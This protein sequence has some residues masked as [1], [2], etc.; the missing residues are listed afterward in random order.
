MDKH[1]IDR[2]KRQVNIV[3][4][5]DSYVRLKKN[6]KN[7]SACCPFH[8][9]KTPSFT[10]SEDKQF[11]YCFGCGAKGD[12]IDWLTE[13]AQMDFV[14]AIKS[15][16]GEIEMTDPAKIA[17]N[18]KRAPSIRKLKDHCEEPE[19][20]NQIL[21]SCDPIDDYY[22]AKNGKVYLPLMSAD[23]ELKNIVTFEEYDK[24]TPIFIAGGVSYDCFYRITNKDSPNWLAVT[25]LKDGYAIA[26][27]TGLNV[28]VCFTGVVLK[29][30]CRWNYGDLK[31]KPVLTP[32]DDDWLAHEMNYLFWDGK[33]LQKR[34]AR[35]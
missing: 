4:I 22:K 34:E 35:L 17:R 18:E 16:G 24:E 7:H 12:V 5:I 26:N 14:D 1:E 6:G 21:S 3:D 25:T 8:S 10:V 19:M 20:C 15:L 28:A 2:L 13:Y 30:V 11:Y 33:E 27:K 9:E 23:G 31:I 29:Y 32:N